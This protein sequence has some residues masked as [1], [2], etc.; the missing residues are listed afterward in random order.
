[1]DRLSIPVVCHT[2][3]QD[4]EKKTPFIHTLVVLPDRYELIHLST[5]PCSPIS[6][7]SLIN[8][9]WWL[10]VSKTALR[11]NRARN[12]PLRSDTNF[13]MSFFYFEQCRLCGMCRLIY[14]DCNG[15]PRL[16]SIKC[17][18]MLSTTCLSMILDRYM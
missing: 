1:M 17:L 16:L 4:A 10:T 18:A 13:M 12:T 6:F 11:S 14:G 9:I 5:L 8:K 2:L 3:N 15:S 7:T